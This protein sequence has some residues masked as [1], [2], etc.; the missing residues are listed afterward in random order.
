MA[1]PK[2]RCMQLERQL[3]IEKQ[4]RLETEQKLQILQ[5]QGSEFNRLQGQIID[6]SDAIATMAGKVETDILPATVKVV[7]LKTR[8]F[9]LYKDMG[10][11]DTKAQYKTL[12]E[13]GEYDQLGP[14]VS[15]IVQGGQQRNTTQTMQPEVPPTESE[16]NQIDGD[17]IISGRQD[18]K[19]EKGDKSG[20]KTRNRGKR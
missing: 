8:L 19:V 13:A 12:L 16:E 1:F 5:K 11:D 20:R 15:A 17:Q 6:L 10:Y 3:S 14:V 18:P 7:N 2:Q 4:R 9:Q